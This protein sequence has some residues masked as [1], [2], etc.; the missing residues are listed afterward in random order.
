MVLVAAGQLCSTSNI[1]RNLDMCRTIIAQAA[2]LNAKVVC[3]PEASDYISTTA[4]ESIRLASTPECSQF[5]EG[6]REAAKKNKVQVNVGVHERSQDK[7][8]KRLSNTSLWID[9]MGIITQRYRKLHLFDVAIKDGPVIK[10]SNSTEPGSSIVSPFDSVCGKIG[11]MICFDLR[12]PELST[13]LRRRG[14]EVLLYPSAFAMRTGVAHWEPLLRARAIETSC[15]VV[16][17][18]QVGAHNEKRSSYGHS[19]VIDPWGSVVAQASD[20]RN[21][22]PSFILANV[23]HAVTEHVRQ[24]MPLIRRNDIYPEI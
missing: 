3:L 4:D 8:E 22:E 21:S 15:W 5:V 2:A 10:E 18:A 23:D 7:N 11:M 20:V 24:G 16:A 14:A 19:M 6:I 12:F 1:L 17:A 9:E 13:A